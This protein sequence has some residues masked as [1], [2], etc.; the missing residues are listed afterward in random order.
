MAK[1]YT[2]CRQIIHFVGGIKRTIDHVVYVYEN[3]MCHI[4][5]LDGTEWVINKNNVLA[6]E[7]IT[8]EQINADS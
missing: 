2:G 7:I 8:G 4:Q 5:T 1:S 6:V 3:E